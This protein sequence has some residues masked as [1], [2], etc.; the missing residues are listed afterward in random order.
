MGSASHSIDTI[1]ERSEM[2]SFRWKIYGICGML[3]ALEGYD[4]YVVANLAATIARGLNI[5]IPAMAYVFIAQGAGMAVGFYTIT[6]LADR[7]GRRNI[8]LVGSVAFGIL[9]IMSSLVSTL[10]EFTFVRFLSFL[11]LGGVF[12]NIIALSSEFM[13]AS[14]RSRLLTWLFIAHGMGASLAGLVG[15][16]FIAY[17][18]W[19][20]AFWAGGV[21]LL[22]FV[23]FLY[24]TLPESCRYLVARDDSDPRIGETLQKVD[25]NFERA[26]G[27]SFFTEELK[28]KGSTIAGLFRDGRTPKTLLLWLGM[29]SSLYATAAIT[30]WLPS[31]LHVLGG[32]PTSTATRMSSF[33]AFGAMSGPIL[34]TYLMKR[35]GT[36]LSL[37]LTC[38][39]AFVSMSALSLVVE[40]PMLGWF[41]G[42]AFGLLVIGSQ[43]GMNALVASSYPTSIRSTG[44]GWAGG[45]GRITS[46][47]GP[48]IGGAVLAAQW[49]TFNIFLAVAGPL[50]LASLAMLIFYLF[51]YD[52]AAL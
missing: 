46:M 38:V 50:V 6:V 5:P 37:C 45:I 17:H 22:L 8:I 23:P 43:A 24:F 18:S 30:A 29:G 48:A 34:L 9:T 16:T 41:V 35:L 39:A 51:R 44:I 14:R 7:I 15:P 19:Q 49:S 40:I 1:L 47:I 12:P 11:A 13:P 27:S 2:G 3:M 33:S 25:P 31:Y 10:T 21:A 52:K 4:A 32:L 26:E 42:L 28:V 20:A 36:P